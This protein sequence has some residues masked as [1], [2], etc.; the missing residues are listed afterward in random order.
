CEQ[1]SVQLKQYMLGVTSLIANTN[2]LLRCRE[3]EP[4]IA[5]IGDNNWQQFVNEAHGFWN[6][7]AQAEAIRLTLSNQLQYIAITVSNVNDLIKMMEDLAQNMKSVVIEQCDR[8]REKGFNGFE[9]PNKE[10]QFNERSG[11][12]KYA[13]DASVHQ[14]QIASFAANFS[15]FFSELERKYD[16]RN[17]SCKGMSK[18]Q[19]RIV[20]F[21][22]IT[23]ILGENT[24]KN[25]GALQKTAQS[26]HE[27][28]TEYLAAKVVVADVCELILPKK[29]KM[30]I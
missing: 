16:P 29:E 10:G 24:E 28:I 25:F 18:Q 22:F 15:R 19:L 6:F 21:Q 17:P 5:E 11:Y 7:E 12:N 20:K 27:Y 30:T 26:L 13:P 23:Q 8:I 3:I 9:L 4:D 14:A 1:V 2:V